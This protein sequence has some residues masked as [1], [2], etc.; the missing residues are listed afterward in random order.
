MDNIKKELNNKLNDLENIINKID[1]INNVDEFNE[2]YVKI[3]S[4][5]NNILKIHLTVK[6]MLTLKDNLNVILNNYILKKQNKKKIEKL[7][8][9]CENNVFVT[10]RN[11]TNEESY[12]N[13]N[14][15]KFSVINI[16][17]KNLDII[18]NT[19]IYYIQETKQYCIK[20]NDNI[21]MGNIGNIYNTTTSNTSEK[22]KK[23]KYNDCDGLF[24]ENTCQYFHDNEKRNFTNYSWN[25]ILNDKNGK[26]KNKNNYINIKKYDINNTRFIGSLET[27]KEDLP[28]SSTYEK[29]LRNGQLMHD[30]LIYLI[31]SKYLSH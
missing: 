20:I 4:Y 17:N 27:L 14:F 10:N 6:K 19:P 23:C 7:D 24:Y 1:K 31:L 16:S 21:I 3:K 5:E 12:N 13:N 22:I 8:N 25:H 15:T 11:V 26:I 28:F 29:S 18:E 9:P 2:I 30:I